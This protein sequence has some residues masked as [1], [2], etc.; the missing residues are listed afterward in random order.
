MEDI[1]VCSPLTIVHR[2]ARRCVSHI[3]IKTFRRIIF[4]EI[5]LS[6]DMGKCI[7]KYQRNRMLWLSSILH[8]MIKVVNKFDVIQKSQACLLTIYPYNKSNLILK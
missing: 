8:R 1:Q 5:G 2:S 6:G 7:E 4:A 3:N